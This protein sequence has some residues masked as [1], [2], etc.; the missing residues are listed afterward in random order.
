MNPLDGFIIDLSLIADIPFYLA[1]V[2]LGVP[3]VKRES[4][5]YLIPTLQSL[6]ES[7]THEEKNISLIVVLIAE[8]I[9]SH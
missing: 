7:M 1:S 6:I 2:V 5:S 4:H 8:V 9:S 3:T